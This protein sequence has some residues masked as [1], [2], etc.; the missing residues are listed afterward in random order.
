M[1]EVQHALQNN[2]H[3]LRRQR[4]VTLPQHLAAS[5]R[6]GNPNLKTLETIAA[7][8]DVEIADLLNVSAAPL[9]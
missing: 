3:Q 4:G 8:L 6:R 2:V 7:L 5:I 1:T 9:D